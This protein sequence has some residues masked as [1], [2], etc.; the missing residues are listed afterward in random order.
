MDGFSSK[1]LDAPVNRD[2]RLT[3]ILLMFILQR[4]REDSS[5]QK[6]A[7]VSFSLDYDKSSQDYSPAMESAVRTV[8]SL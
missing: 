8:G 1:S 7:T 6:A 5:E 4:S 3:F 2:A